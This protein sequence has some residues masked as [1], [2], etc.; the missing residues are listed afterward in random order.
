MTLSEG[1]LL[2][3][4]SDYFTE[5]V[6]IMGSL[7]KENINKYL[8][9]ELLYA[10]ELIR[11]ASGNKSHTTKNGAL[12]FVYDSPKP[13][14]IS[15]SETLS[16]TEHLLDSFIDGMTVDKTSDVTSQVR[17]LWDLRNAP[18]V[19]NFESTD[20]DNM[21]VAVE[22]LLNTFCMVVLVLGVILCVITIPN[23]LLFM[24]VFSVALPVLGLVFFEWGYRSF[25][26]IWDR[27]FS[28]HDIAHHMPFV[29]GYMRFLVC[30]E[31]EGDDRPRRVNNRIG[32]GYV[33]ALGIVSS[34][35]WAFALLVVT[36][37]S[38]ATGGLGVDFSTFLTY[39]VMMLIIMG[40]SSLRYLR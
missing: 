26:K 27:P 14:L 17:H 31:L 5:L 4:Y 9:Y 13:S 29:D 20:I 22:D 35:M 30:S 39:I 21:H 24:R 16:A 18:R 32:L 6:N 38:L 40:L 11:R 37:L 3:R 33:A 15:D 7:N 19:D 28:I 36:L 8:A 10:Q 1:K 12:A 2:L 25:V 23:L 34:A